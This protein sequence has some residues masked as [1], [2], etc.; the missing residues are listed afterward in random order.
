MNIYFFTL[1]KGIALLKKENCIVHFTPSCIVQFM[2]VHVDIDNAFIG[3]SL[4]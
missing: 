2:D 4:M 3:Y 1:R